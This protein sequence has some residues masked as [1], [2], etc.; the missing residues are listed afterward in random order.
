MLDT[1]ALFDADPISH[2]TL[3]LPIDLRD[4]AQ[5]VTY[6]SDGNR[7]VLRE[8]T[9]HIECVTRDE[10]TGFTRCGHKSLSAQSDFRAKL[11]AQGMSFMEVSS[12]VVEAREKGEIP[13]TNY[14]SM[15]YR[16]YEEDDRLKLLWVVYLPDATAEELGM[17]L[18]PQ[19]DQSLAG[20]GRP[21]MMREGTP[22]AHLMIPI[23]STALSN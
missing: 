12:A 14:G 11:S 13:A 2:A 20:L 3:P 18:A 1:K 6:D 19:R 16:L 9:N 8:G 7:Q 10:A 23:N 21:W 4:G 5:V 17:S 22:S 15:I